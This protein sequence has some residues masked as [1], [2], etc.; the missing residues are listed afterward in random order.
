MRRVS[1]HR[2]TWMHSSVI[3]I[4][5]RSRRDI[6]SA[7]LNE[8][9]QTHSRWRDQHASQRLSAV[10][11]DLVANE[12]SR[13][14]TI[15]RHV[16]SQDVEEAMAVSASSISPFTQLNELLVLGTLTI[17]LENSRDEEILASHPGTEPFSI[18]KLSDGERNA[19]I[20]AAT[21]LTAAPGTVLLIDEPERHL[22]RAIIEPFLLALFECR[23]DCPFIVSTH[24]IALPAASPGARVLMPRSC[25]WNG[26][27][28]KAWDIHVL[29]PHTALPE[30]LKLA[31]LGSRRRIL[32]VEGTLNSLDRPL[33]GALFPGTSVVPRDGC[34][35]VQRAV[36]GLRAA[37]DQHHVEA[38]GLVDRD[39]R[40][41]EQVDKLSKQGVF[42]LKVH[43]AEAIYY[44]LEA[45]TAVAE[46][47]AES[48][49]GNADELATR[50]ISSALEALR[51]KGIA[52]RMAAR[53]CHGKM[54][55]SIISHL[56]DWQSIQ[57]SGGANIQISVSSPYPE[58]LQR[59]ERLLTSA[60]WDRL[61]AS[62]PL[63]ETPAFSRIV[64]ELQ[65]S[66]RSNYEQ[67]V[68]AR[69]K[70]DEALADRLRE[71]IDRL[72]QALRSKAVCNEP[73]VA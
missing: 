7:T 52:E 59:F 26:D 65:C 19:V 9:A 5:A 51:Q 60:E 43:S 2:Q 57:D 47:Q 22:H 67:M 20:I 30:E 41:D 8:D 50:A 36:M 63:R 34:A 32:F 62:Y 61:V 40:S 29:E 71:Q 14:R 28:P 16:D 46:R 42:A 4:T 56:P 53:R 39:D 31:I 72:S 23:T 35:A 3:D 58:E 24:E 48:L 37:Y 27:S 45:I 25:E 1:A 73:D 54:R 49:G 12:N 38:F 10:L 55:D 70:A 44:G 66:S 18:V 68:L 21:V 33:Y 69:I 6:E 15:T 13:A 17:A 64:K 11:F